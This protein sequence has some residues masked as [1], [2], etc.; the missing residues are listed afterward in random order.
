M[1]SKECEILDEQ[2]KKGN[3]SAVESGH[4]EP[5]THRSVMKH[6]EEERRKWKEGCE[7]EL[8]DFN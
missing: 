1:Q 3:H 7:K 6:P 5:K 2:C 8:R 4:K